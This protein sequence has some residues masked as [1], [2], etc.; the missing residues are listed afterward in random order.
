MKRNIHLFLLV[1]AFVVPNIFVL[2]EVT[3][4]RAAVKGSGLPIPRFVATKAGRT[5]LRAG[6]GNHYPVRWVY[7]RKDIPLKVVAEFDFWRKVQ[8]VDGDEGWIHKNL[9]MNSHTVWIKAPIVEVLASPEAL[10]KIILKAEKGVEAEFLKDTQGKYAKVRI[11][12]VKG[13]VLT[14]HIWGVLP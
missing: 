3:A 4:A 1:L 2:G 8:D 10:D 7:L 11:Q 5:N 14:E 6:P 9:L 13:W 12:G